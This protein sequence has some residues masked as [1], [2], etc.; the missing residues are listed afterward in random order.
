ML[1]SLERDL[2]KKSR[3][4]VKTNVLQAY[5]I[6]L[7]L[8]TLKINI[9]VELQRAPTISKFE[10]LFGTACAK[11][12]HNQNHRNSSILQQR[13]LSSTRTGARAE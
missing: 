11:H 1:L 6:E 8:I 10:I 4:Q 3:A 13:S 7:Q 2:A 12:W 9:S 5:R